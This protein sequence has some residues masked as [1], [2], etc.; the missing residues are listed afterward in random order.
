LIVFF[1]GVRKK[2]E[3]G[4]PVGSPLVTRREEAGKVELVQ[5]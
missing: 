2:N 1:I 5:K 3:K 4:W